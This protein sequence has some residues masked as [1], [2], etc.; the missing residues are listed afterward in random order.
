MAEE[1]GS[2]RS[3]LFWKNIGNAA[4]FLEMEQTW[5]TG[6]KILVLSIWEKTKLC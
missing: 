6:R 5:R 1:V 3:Y 4:K 2:M